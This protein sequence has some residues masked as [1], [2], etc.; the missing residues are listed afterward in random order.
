MSAVASMS[1]S[2]ASLLSWLLFFVA[3]AAAASTMSF[4][5]SIISNG[6]SGGGS[7]GCLRTLKSVFTVFFFLLTCRQHAIVTVQNIVFA[8][9]RCHFVTD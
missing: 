8:K 5:V 3:T 6:G 1:K 4:A 7:G 2:D 9:H